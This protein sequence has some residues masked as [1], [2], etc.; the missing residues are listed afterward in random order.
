[1][2][3]RRTRDETLIDLDAEPGAPLPEP[4]RTGFGGWVDDLFGDEDDA[5]GPR[6]TGEGST[7]PGSPGQGST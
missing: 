2:R 5:P 1:L 7:A 3:T 6:P 4:D